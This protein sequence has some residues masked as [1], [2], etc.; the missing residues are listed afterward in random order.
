[1][2]WCLLK[3]RYCFAYFRMYLKLNRTYCYGIRGITLSLSCYA[4]YLYIGY[5]R[6]AAASIIYYN[7]TAFL[8]EALSLSYI[9]SS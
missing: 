3:D 6:S 8:L 7:V 2:N 1:M 9:V 5:C 4:P